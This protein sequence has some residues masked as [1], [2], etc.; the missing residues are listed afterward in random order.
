MYVKITQRR[1]NGR[2]RSQNDVACDNGTFG[3]LS[4]FVMSNHPVLYLY[5]WGPTST[6]MPDALAPIFQPVI[7]T[8][9]ERGMIV[10]GMQRSSMSADE[11]AATCLQEWTIEFQPTAPLS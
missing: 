2:R 6:N 10:R 4:G 7:V 11:D 3:R 9:S 1:E 8:L 5:E